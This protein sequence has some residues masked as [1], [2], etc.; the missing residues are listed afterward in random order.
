LTLE[1]DTIE[2][3]ENEIIVKGT[4]LNTGISKNWEGWD[5]GT[6]FW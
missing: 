5:Y 4:L 1:N 6:Y 2:I 3:K